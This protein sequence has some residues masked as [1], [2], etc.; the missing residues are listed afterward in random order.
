[1]ISNTYFDLYWENPLK[2][3]NKIKKYF[4]PIKLNIRTAFHKSNY[5]K[6]LDFNSFDLMW[7]DKYDTPRHEFS[8]RIHIHIF[9]YIHIYIT[10][11]LDE[12]GLADMVAWESVLYWLYYNKTLPEALEEASGW[13]QY[14][15]TS[16]TYEKIK[17]KILREPW[18]TQYE[19]NQLKEIYYESTTR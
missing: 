13:S 19:N 4:K 10:F 5:A 16:N 2:T 18:Q 12:D 15:P 7:K 9:N 3:Y 14:Y 17:F 8:P 6:I 11:M 1:M